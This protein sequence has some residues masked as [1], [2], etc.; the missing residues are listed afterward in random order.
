MKKN[1]K[2]EKE[3]IRRI[4]RTANAE[5]LFSY[6]PIE[7]KKKFKEKAYREG[8]DMSQVLRELVIKYTRGE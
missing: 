7:L 1:S 6:V 3:S 4:S 5:V 2:K 8:K